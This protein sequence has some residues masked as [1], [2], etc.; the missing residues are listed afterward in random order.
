[1]AGGVASG[2]RS[3]GGA[4]QALVRRGGLAW[5]IRERVGAEKY[6]LA[7]NRRA[8]SRRCPAYRRIWEGR[9]FGGNSKGAPSRLMNATITTR[10]P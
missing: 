6:S 8:L 2:G 10:R 7:V 9:V 1:V 5:L 4:Q 3:G